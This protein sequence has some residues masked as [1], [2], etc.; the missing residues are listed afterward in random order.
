MTVLLVCSMGGHLAE[1]RRLEAAFHGHRTV[2]VTYRSPVTQDLPEAY[3][4]TNFRTNPLRYAWGLVQAWRIFR[5][6]RP[7]MVVSTGSEIAL[8][9]FVVA[10][11]CGV[12]AIFVESVARVR[13]LSGTGRLLLPLAT[14]FYAQWP[15]L[16]RQ[17]ARIRY[18]G[19][20]L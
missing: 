17:D 3:L 10:R 19:G 12:P 4:L 13:S 6:E 5:R 14:R 15:G 1:M 18:V 9:F 2:L 16:A 7:T 11:A 20:L 8:P